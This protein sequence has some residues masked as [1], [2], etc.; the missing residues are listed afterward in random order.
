MVL[1]LLRF[2][3][4]AV[5]LIGVYGCTTNFRSSNADYV[6]VSSLNVEHE[7]TPK[8]M[9]Q[10]QLREEVERFAF[11]YAGRLDPYFEAIANEVNTPEQRLGINRWKKTIHLF[12]RKD[13]D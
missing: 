9:T 6:D 11:R 4:L 13:C 7:A 3:V 12:T 1:S 10:A 8:H 2:A 5:L